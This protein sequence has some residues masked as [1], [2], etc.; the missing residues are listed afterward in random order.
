MTSRLYYKLTV[1]GLILLLIPGCWDY[2]ELTYQVYP[3]SLGIDYKDGQFTVYLQAL[4]FSGIGKQEETTMENKPTLIGTETGESITDAIFQLYRTAQF[5]VYWGH[6]SAL[7]FSEEALQQVKFED[8]VDL[9]NR[10]REIRYNVWVFGTNGSMEKIYNVKSFFGLPPY[11]SI[12]MEPEDTY[13]QYSDI[14]P[15]YLFQFMAYYLEPGRTAA[16]PLLSYDSKDWEEGGKP[17]I[18]MEMLGAYFFHNRSYRGKLMFADLLGKRFMDKTMVRVPIA[19]N[20]NGQTLMTF[21]VEVTDVKIDH[22]IVDGKVNYKLSLKVKTHINE[23]K[24]QMELASMVEKIQ[25]RIEQEIRKSFE[26]GLSINAD[27]YNLN[28]SVYRYD[29]KNWK[30]YIDGKTMQECMEL[31]EVDVDVIIHDSGKHKNKVITGRETG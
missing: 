23:M 7:L 21:V 2:K 9:V 1:I 18:Q 20:E 30:E 14:E 11:E 31:K 8:L 16:L 5:R 4:N 28:D 26:K 19:I 6:I 3:T 25:K 13:K 17:A 22:K 29:N 27:I 10:Y 12:L 24:Q 15:L